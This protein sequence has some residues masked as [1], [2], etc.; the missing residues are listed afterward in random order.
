MST[1]GL[2]SIAAP[3]LVW[4]GHFVFS[5]AVA[6]VVCAKS[7]PVGGLRGAI[8][9]ATALALALVARQ[10]ASAW[11]KHVRGAEPHDAPN[12]EGRARF[13]GHLVA[14]CAALSGVAVVYSAAVFLVVRSCE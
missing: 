3:L 4:A 11:S 6:A 5:Y 7:A 1:P 10:G 9:L 14:L 13:V 8:A 2:A 12:D